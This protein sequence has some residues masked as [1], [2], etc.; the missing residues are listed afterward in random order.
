MMPRLRATTILAVRHQGRIAIGGDGQ[1][2]LGN[3][4]MKADAH[5]IRRLAEG[6]VLAGFA[7]SA[8]D[9]FALLERFES[10]LRDFGGSVPRAATELAKDWRT[11][12][13]LRRLEA[14]LIV[15]DRQHLLLLSGTGDV[16]QPTDDILAIGSGG[17]YAL[18]AARALKQH[19]QLSAP[20]IVR[21][22]LEI[23]GDLCI[24]TNRNIDV[25][26]LA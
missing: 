14:M 22:G 5:K 18:A 20:D 8:A 21:A 23:A 10:K 15:A 19:S 1:V 4:V 2:T 24:Y 3:I 12:R 16:I 11:D 9:A 26:E 7:G 17:P 13:A 6:K 25:Q